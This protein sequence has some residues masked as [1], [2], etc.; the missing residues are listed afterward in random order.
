MDIERERGQIPDDTYTLMVLITTF[1]GM[2]DVIISW[3]IQPYVHFVHGLMHQIPAGI[4]IKLNTARMSVN[5]DGHDYV[6][7]LI[8]TWSQ[9]PITVPEW[10]SL[11]DQLGGYQLREYQFSSPKGKLIGYWLNTNVNQENH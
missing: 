10:F 11:K 1:K 3:V 8:A 6:L 7:N 2:P 4:T 9:Q 5:E